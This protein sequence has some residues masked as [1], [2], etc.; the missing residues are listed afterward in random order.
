MGKI[1]YKVNGY[2]HEIKV[3]GE[4]EAVAY[5]QESNEP[6]IYSVKVDWKKSEA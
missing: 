4:I 6:V 5:D 1:Q 2:W 3:D